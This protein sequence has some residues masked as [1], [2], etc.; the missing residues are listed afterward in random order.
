MEA[1]SVAVRLLMFALA[2]SGTSTAVDLGHNQNFDSGFVLTCSD[3][4]FP[5][6]S[7]VS[8][9][10][11][12]VDIAGDGSGTLSYPLTQENEGN[13]TCTHDGQTSHSFTLAGI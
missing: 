5:L 7:G 6:T 8:F 2:C 1:K 11:N 9:Q 12:G 13:F 3:G 4:L 10:R